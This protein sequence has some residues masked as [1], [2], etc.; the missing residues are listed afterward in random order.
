MQT[1]QLAA[2]FGMFMW[3]SDTPAAAMALQPTSIYM[4]EAVSGG[5]RH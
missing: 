1:R 2:Y 3:C 5:L 4:W